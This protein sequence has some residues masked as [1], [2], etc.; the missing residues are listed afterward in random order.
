M[1]GEAEHAFS[2]LS[3]NGIPL[4]VYQPWWEEGIVH[5]MTLSDRSFGGDLIEHEAVPLCN[6]LGVERLIALKQTHGDHIFDASALGVLAPEALAPGACIRAGEYDAI[7]IR[8]KNGG[9]GERV[10]LGVTTADCVPIII[11]GE[12]GWGIV[13]AGWRGLANGIV[14]EV[15]RSLG[16][17]TQAAI[18][19]CAGGGRYEVGQE[20]VEAIGSSSHYTPLPNGKA[21]LDTG[22]TAQ[23]QLSEFVSRERIDLSGICT[24]VDHRFHSHRRDGETA[25][26]ALTFLVVES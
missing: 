2:F 18:F 21:L 13:H 6:A 11:R 7:I 12:V 9:T 19:P 1:T 25:G 24:I 16:K 26:R 20:V 15:A 3:H 14:R 23:N 17:I 22:L 5:G 8:S 10:A 4:L